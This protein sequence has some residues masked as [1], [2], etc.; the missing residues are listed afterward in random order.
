MR[1]NPSVLVLLLATLTIA[2]C[3]QP[4]PS[5]SVTNE[6]SYPLH[7]VALSAVNSFKKA[8]VSMG[9]TK[10]VVP[11]PTYVGKTIAI[12]WYIVGAPKSLPAVRE[13][14]VSIPQNW[15]GHSPLTLSFSQ[16]KKWAASAH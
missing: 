6:S 10:A 8:T 7:I 14:L 3:A 1:N 4:F 13:T 5:I 2:G 12:K 15:D 16:Q 11:Q 9:E